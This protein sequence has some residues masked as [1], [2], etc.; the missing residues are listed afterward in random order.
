MGCPASEDQFE[1]L[2]CHALVIQAMDANTLHTSSILDGA[3]PLESGS[4]CGSSLLAGRH[5]SSVCCRAVFTTTFSSVSRCELCVVAKVLV[6]HREKVD[7]PVVYTLADLE[8]H[9]AYS[10]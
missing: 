8:A 5:G 4:S 2:M 6:G 9:T 1:V 10:V 7:I 3:V